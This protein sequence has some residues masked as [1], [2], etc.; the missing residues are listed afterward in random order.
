[1]IT[2]EKLRTVAREL[3]HEA[4]DYDR[5]QLSAQ[6]YVRR[7]AAKAMMNQA[8]TIERED[9]IFDPSPGGHGVEATR[10]NPSRCMLRKGL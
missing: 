10:A 9:A 2:I 1:M 5:R 7:E 8:D 6:A 3:A 4:R